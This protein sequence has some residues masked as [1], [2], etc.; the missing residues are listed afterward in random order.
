MT[1]QFEGLLPLAVAGIVIAAVAHEGKLLRNQPDRLKGAHRT[2]DG[3]AS[4]KPGCL[5]DSGLWYGITTVEGEERMPP[6][7][8]ER[9]ALPIEEREIT[10]RW[11]GKR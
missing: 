9:T 1:L 2:R 11:P 5:R 10:G 4:I 6:A 3:F 7:K 8:A